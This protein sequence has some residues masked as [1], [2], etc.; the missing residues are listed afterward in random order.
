M[1][2]DKESYEYY[3]K[4]CHFEKVLA[5]LQKFQNY[6]NNKKEKPI[7]SI[8]VMISKET[9]LHKFLSLWAPLVDRV[10][11]SATGNMIKWNSEKK[12]ERLKFEGR[13]KENMWKHQQKSGYKYCS[14]PFEE[15]VVSA[16]GNAILCCNDFDNFTQMIDLT[17]KSIKDLLNTTDRKKCQEQFLKQ[18]MDICNGCG[19]FEEITTESQ[20]EYDKKIEK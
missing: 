17:K 5:N 10:D 9:N 11:Y 18:K 14:A 3:R 13:L 1:G 16:K 2:W 8:L 15:V 6:I 12:I 4:N 20:K 19:V 7:T